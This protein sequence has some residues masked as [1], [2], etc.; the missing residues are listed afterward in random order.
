MT[1]NAS[2]QP[3]PFPYKGRN[4][5][6]KT[7]ADRKKVKQYLHTHTATRFEIA[8][9]TGIGIQYVCRH[10]AELKKHNEVA[11]IKKG[12]CS[13]SNY[14]D[15]EKLSSDPAKFPKPSQLNLFDPCQ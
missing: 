14:P 5:D 9:H 8:I 7:I 13:I 4:K 12:R 3:T 15:V 11:V 1:P 2:N 6:T 10:I